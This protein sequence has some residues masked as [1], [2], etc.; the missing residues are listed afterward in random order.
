MILVF[1]VSCSRREYSISNLGDDSFFTYF[2]LN[3]RTFVGPDTDN[4][5]YPEVK[6][7][8][9]EDFLSKRKLEEL[10]HAYFALAK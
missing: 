5:N 3:G 8:T 1:G 2:W 7:E 9:W 10:T 4:A 6:P